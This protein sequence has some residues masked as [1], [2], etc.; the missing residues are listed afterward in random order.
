MTMIGMNAMT[1]PVW[2]TPS[3]AAS[4]PQWATALTAPKDAPSESR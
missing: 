1:G 2:L 3:G 4:Q